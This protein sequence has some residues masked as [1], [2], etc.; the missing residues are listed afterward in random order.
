[1]NTVM[2]RIASMYAYRV[3]GDT[4]TVARSGSASGSEKRFG[5]YGCTTWRLSLWTTNEGH[6]S[7]DDVN[8][9]S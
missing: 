4:S 2:G 7:V 5:L 6:A 1:M 9:I 8:K 3:G